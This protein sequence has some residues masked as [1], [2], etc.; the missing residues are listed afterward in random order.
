[1]ATVSNR[2][3]A[4]GEIAPVLHSRV[5]MVKY[6][7]GL[8]ILRNSTV[9]RHGGTTNRPGTIFVGSA[10]YKAQTHGSVR[11]IDFVYNDSQSYVL[12]FGNLYIK[13]I[14]NGEY[15]GGTLVGNITGITLSLIHI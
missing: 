1:M 9:M 5:D 7:T 13:V 12:E 11:L 10:W 4:G 6:E 2:S 15:L 3:F 8:K 14:Q